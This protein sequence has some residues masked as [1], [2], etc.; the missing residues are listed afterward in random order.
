MA[1]RPR[2]RTISIVALVEVVSQLIQKDRKVVLG[3]SERHGSAQARR[4]QWGTTRGQDVGPPARVSAP[5]IVLEGLLGVGGWRTSWCSCTSPRRSWRTGFTTSDGA[6]RRRP[7][8][9]D[10]VLWFRVLI[11]RNCVFQKILIWLRRES[12]Q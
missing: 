11:S 5:A 4:G 3:D 6:E 8:E 7:S 12:R 1:P 10:I 9:L 2:A